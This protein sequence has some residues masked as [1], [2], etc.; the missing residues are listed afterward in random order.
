MAHSNLAYAA[1]SKLLDAL[2]PPQCMRCD[3]LIHQHGAL[4]NDCWQELHFI[5]APMCGHCG[6]PFEYDM[7]EGALCGACIQDLPAY[8]SAYSALVFDDVSKRLLHR[9]K[10]E[11]QGHLAPILA[12]W[13]ASHMQRAQSMDAIIPVPLSR[14]RLFSRRYNQSALVAKPLALRLGIAYRPEWLLR[15]KHTKPQTGLTRSQRQENVA[16]AFAVPVA[17][18]PELIG[19]SVVLLDDVLTTGATIEACTK[20]LR[21]GGAQHIHVL[22]L[23]RVIQTH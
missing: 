4:C 19:K 6:H 20:A 14:K 5:T 9:L 16:S 12:D 2:F 11:D 8:D 3:V 7:G 10:Y 13:L 1:S 22:T 21:K 15:I 23:A 18:Q 17:K